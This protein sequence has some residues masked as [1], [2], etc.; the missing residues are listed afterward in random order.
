MKY[1]FALLLALL[2]GAALAQ[3]SAAPV[4]PGYLTNTAQPNC[5]VGPCF[6]AFTATNPQPVTVATSAGASGSL[7]GQTT[8]SCGTGDTL[9]L[10]AAAAT[11]FVTIKAPNGTANTVWLSFTGAAAVAASPSFDLAS[12]SSQTFST[13]V[14]LPTQQFR[15]ISA[16][17]AQAVTLVYK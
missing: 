9:L 17:G 11:T 13:G 8:V 5:P 4:Q 1:I 7:T 6:V 16:P 2:P 12:G 3:V 14:F 10:A 15:C